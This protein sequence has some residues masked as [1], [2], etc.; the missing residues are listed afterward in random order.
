MWSHRHSIRRVPSGQILRLI[1]EAEA[2]VVWSA[3]A[4]ASTN[5]AFTTPMSALGLWFADL[6]SENCPD[7]SVIEFTFFWK[8]AGRWEGTNYSVAVTG[9]STRA[10]G[11]QKIPKSNCR[12]R[13][14]TR[15]P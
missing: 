3:N 15:K 9:Q 2:T 8:A 11:T 12:S 1:V 5:N 13:G 4:W 14:A 6:P 7:G 10:S